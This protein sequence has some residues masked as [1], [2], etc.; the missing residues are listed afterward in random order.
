MRRKKQ[1]HFFK[2]TVV[3][4]KFCVILLVNIHNDFILKS[5]YIN[6]I[7]EKS[8]GLYEIDLLLGIAS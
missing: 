1:S 7:F 5:F 8:P 4:T 2:K 6:P 3:V